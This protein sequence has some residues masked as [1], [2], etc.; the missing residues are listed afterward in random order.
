MNLA[1]ADLVDL[2]YSCFGGDL[3]LRLNGVDFSIVTGGGV[4]ILD[5]AVEFFS[6]GRSVATGKPGKINFAGMADEIYVKPHEESVE[7]SSNY[8]DEVGRVE[9]QQFLRAGRTFLAEVLTDLTAEYPDL[10][11][12]QGIKKAGAWVGL[13]I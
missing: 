5:F 4:Q 1:K 6:A 12:N 9:R 7:I 13:T 2:C 10:R 11:R 3:T 8:T